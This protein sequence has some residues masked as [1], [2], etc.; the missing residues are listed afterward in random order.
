[1]RARRRMANEPTL[2]KRPARTTGRN[3]TKPVVKNSASSD[4]KPLD[5]RKALGTSPL[6]T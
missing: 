3:S 5:S 4:R 1:M 2:P 6:G